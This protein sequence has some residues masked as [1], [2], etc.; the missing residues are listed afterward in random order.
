MTDKKIL[1][2]LICLGV[3]FLLGGLGGGIAGI[4]VS[5]LGVG[6]SFIYL[7]FFTF[8]AKNLIVP[9]GFGV[10]L[11]FLALLL[12]N[13]FFSSKKDSTLNYFLIYLS[14]GI[15]YLLFYNLAEKI[16]NG[17]EKL[18]LTVGLIFAA[19]LAIFFIFKGLPT[20]PGSLFL[21]AASYRNHNHIG[22]FWVI[23]LIVGVYRFLQGRQ[24]L[25]LFIL[26]LGVIL[27]AISLSRSA[28]LGVIV[29]LAYLFWKKGGFLSNQKA[30][31]ASLSVFLGLFLI[32]SFFKSTLFSRA[33]YFVQAAYGAFKYPFGVGV[34]NFEL[35]SKDPQSHL[36]GLGNFSTMTHSIVLEFWV[37]MGIFAIVFVVWLIKTILRLR[38]ANNLLFFALWIA[39][40]VNFLL[41]STYIIPTM[42]WVWFCLLGLA[43]NRVVGY[44]IMEKRQTL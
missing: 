42:V 8:K 39:V 14:G 32:G 10:Y 30:F 38:N 4:W 43:E 41:D 28:Y 24:K 40:L 21:P 25:Y 19:L 2:F 15:F 11:V 5:F 26:A 12:S 16:E 9:K 34:G 3:L 13:V 23:L 35:V 22:D 33:H 7:L 20:T 17:F 44:E 27:E 31:K 6:A 18:L 1:F 36:F 37:G 29:A